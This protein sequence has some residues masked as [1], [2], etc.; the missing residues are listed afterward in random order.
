MINNSFL[1]LN[2]SYIA[3]STWWQHVPVAH[4]LVSAMQPRL[5]VELGTHY[6][7]SFFAFCEAAEAFSPNTF[8]FAVDTW[9]GDEHA[10]AYSETVY[11]AVST[12]CLSRHRKRASLVR[13]T[14]DEAAAYFEQSSIDVLH[15]DGLHTYEAVKHDFETWLPLLKDDSIVFLHDIN[16]RERNFGVWRFWQEL[17]ASDEYSAIEILN[18]YG[19]GILIKGSIYKKLVADSVAI[20][21]L[22]VAKGV[23]L[24]KLAENTPGGSFNK[25]RFEIQ[26]EQA[27]A[28]AEQARAE[29]EQ[30]NVTLRN[31]INSK[32]FKLVRFVRKML[33]LELI[34]PRQ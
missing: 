32:S 4:W 5:I 16:V 26:A 13:S 20:I 24:E 28:E 3:P 1:E 33:G 31:L 2:P 15:I 9:E 17:K 14:F 12:H 27:R 34:V 11:N 23:L 10:G 18:G 30:A 29:A 22:L 25:S 19:L 6:G 21:P 7:V 8:V